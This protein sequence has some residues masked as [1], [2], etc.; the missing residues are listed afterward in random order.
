[1]G[2]VGGADAVVVTGEQL[3]DMSES[4]LDALLAQEHPLV[5]DS[6]A[7]IVTAIE[8]CRRCFDNVR[9]FLFYIFTH[10]TPEVVPFVVFA[11][12]G[13]AVPLPPPDPA[14]AGVRRGHRDPAAPGAGPRACR[15]RDH[16]APA[17]APEPGHR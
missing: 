9:K 10:I 4:D 3:D 11:M 6:F 12:A 14:A 15:A 16:P 13:G 17:S 2:I 7:T 1:V 5:F 8:G